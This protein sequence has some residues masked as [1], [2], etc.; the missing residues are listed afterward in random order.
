MS[1]A[2]PRKAAMPALLR[3]GLYLL[4]AGTLGM[5]ALGTFHVMQDRANLRA[6][7]DRLVAWHG[8]NKTVNKRLAATYKDADGGLLAD[9]PSDPQQWLDPDT[10][11]LAHYIDADADAQIVAWEDLQSHLAQATGKTIVLQEY[12]NTA[13]DVAE[14]KAGTIQLVALHAADT[15]YVVNNAGFVPVAVLGTATG[16]HGNRLDI[17]VP[18]DSAIKTLADLRTRTLTCTAPDSITGYR[19]A[20][21][22]LAQD[23]AMRPDVDYSL[24]FSHGQKRSIQ[25]LVKGDFE[26]AALSDDKVQS[27][28][29]KGTLE[30][31]QYRV[32]F[33][34][35]VIPRLTIGNVYNLAPETAAKVTAAIL[36]FT[37]EKGASEDDSPE[38]M[39]FY[40]VDYPKDFEFVRR[41]DDSFDPRF[42][43]NLKPVIS[44]PDE[45]AAASPPAESSNKPAD[46]SAPDEH[47]GAQ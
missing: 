2:S 13:D 23:T 15:P 21:A 3:T 19:A 34:S 43:K 31:S 33:Q 20:I 38:P 26:V 12:R 37:N 36:S 17:A 4:L 5:T 39:R 7:E 45:T 46:A 32:I 29:K 6:T 44:V 11:V 28:L 16:A 1:Q 25:G 22:V 40:P 35:E 41:I 9:P 47:A 24:N 8:L 10:L 42:S 18:T 27:M 14:I 30:E